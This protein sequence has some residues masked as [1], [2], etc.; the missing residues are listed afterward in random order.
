MQ[1]APSGPTWLCISILGK[2]QR[3]A[4]TRRR[5]WLQLSDKT[6]GLVEKREA[7][8]CRRQRAFLFSRFFPPF[9]T[10]GRMEMLNVCASFQILG[11]GGGMESGNQENALTARIDSLVLYRLA[12]PGRIRRKNETPNNRKKKKQLS[13]SA[14]CNR[15]RFTLIQQHNPLFVASRNGPCAPAAPSPPPSKA[16]C[17]NVAPTSRE[18]PKPRKRFKVLELLN[19]I[20][21]R[22]VIRR[23]PRPARPR[24][25]PQNLLIHAQS[26]PR[27]KLTI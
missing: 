27:N 24:W 26:R 19:L 18:R 11:E 10:L 17:A 15:A 12:S 4:T 20:R 8:T 3:C 25:A 6:G 13:P 14:A 2:K 23:H 7:V 21:R 5:T 9:L 22:L 16:G 1:P